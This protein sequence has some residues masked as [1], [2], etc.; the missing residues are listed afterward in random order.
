M[1]KNHSLTT[2]CQCH[3]HHQQQDVWNGAAVGRKVCQNHRCIISPDGQRQPS[4]RSLQK[5]PNGSARGWILIKSQTVQSCSVFRSRIQFHRDFRGFRVE[6][7]SLFS[8][9]CSTVCRYDAKMLLLQKERRWREGWL[10]PVNEL[11]CS[12]NRPLPA[13]SALIRKPRICASSSSRLG[14]TLLG[15]SVGSALH[16]YN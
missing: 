7:C 15:R 16:K 10:L 8:S 3:G 6:I 2:C 14:F 9:G 4:M 11:I 13:A 1:E 12:S 5:W